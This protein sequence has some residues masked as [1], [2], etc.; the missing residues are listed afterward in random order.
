V[1]EEDA[2]QPNSV[3]EAVRKVV[4]EVQSGRQ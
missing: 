4:T 3:I 2:E 1:I